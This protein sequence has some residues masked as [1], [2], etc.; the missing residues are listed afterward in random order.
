ML[1]S[2]KNRWARLV[3]AGCGIWGVVTLLLACWAEALDG[4]VSW[5]EVF[6][7]ATLPGI[8]IAAV[9]ALLALL[10]WTVSG[11]GRRT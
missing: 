10:R 5:S 6:W 2:I 3:A 11:F 7:V 9:L 8:T 1:N 4:D